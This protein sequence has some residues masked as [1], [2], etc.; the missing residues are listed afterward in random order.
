MQYSD[1][2]YYSETKTPI[3]FM[4]DTSNLKAY[5]NSD[6]YLRIGGQLIPAW[7]MLC[8][9]TNWELCATSSRDGIVSLV[10]LH[11]RFLSSLF[12]LVI[13]KV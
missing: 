3:P 7:H 10:I 5:S 13:H 6:D 9:F 11:N 4:Y 12:M 1:V 2:L 8:D